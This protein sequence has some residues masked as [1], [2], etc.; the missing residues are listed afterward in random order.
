MITR[1]ELRRDILEG[2]CRCAENI[3]LLFYSSP[4][5]TNTHFEGRECPESFKPGVADKAMFLRIIEG[6]IENVL[7]EYNEGG[8][9]L[10]IGI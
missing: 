1:E 3:D 8:R 10:Q 9:K 5:L 2:M 4:L 7:K 6:V